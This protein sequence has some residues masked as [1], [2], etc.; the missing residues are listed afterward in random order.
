MLFGPAMNLATGRVDPTYAGAASAM[1]NASQQIGAAVGTALLNAVAVGAT[2][3]HL[4]QR[5]AGSAAAR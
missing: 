3:D 5:G 2:N 1:V 4:A